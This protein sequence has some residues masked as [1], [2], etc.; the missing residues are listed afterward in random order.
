MP[1]CTHD[2]RHVGGDLLSPPCV[3][4]WA[5]PLHG[6]CRKN[7]KNLCM[8]NRHWTYGRKNSVKKMYVVKYTMA[9]RTRSRNY[10]P[11]MH[12][13]FCQHRA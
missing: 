4:S 10:L 8:K 9:K 3:V 11:I 13:Y 12:V 7:S 6:L 2:I 1:T 5:W